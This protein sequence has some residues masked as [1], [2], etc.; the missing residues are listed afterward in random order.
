MNEISCGI[1][2]FC[3]SHAGVK[4]LIVRDKGAKIWNFP[5]GILEENES[6]IEAAERELFEETQV[7]CYKI[8]TEKSFSLG[9]AY[10]QHLDTINKKVV[11]FVGFFSNQNIQ[12]QKTELLDYKLV[13]CD[14]ALDKLAFK[15][16]KILFSAATQFIS[17]M[18]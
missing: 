10:T 6:L 1:I 7:R 17:E 5:K 15:N 11:F 13:D 18:V 16:Q 3:V 8:F 2:P 4:V 14:E 12:L 9:Y